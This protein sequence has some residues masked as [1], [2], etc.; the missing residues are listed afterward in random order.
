MPRGRAWSKAEIF[1]LVEAFVHISEDEIVRVNQRVETLYEHVVAKAK[2]SYA[3]D[4]H[5]GEGTVG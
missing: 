1:A 5:H 3:G 4:W 2:S